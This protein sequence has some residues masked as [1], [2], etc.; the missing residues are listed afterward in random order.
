MA[1][2][3]VLQKNAR[4]MRRE[5]TASERKLWSLLRGGRV[6]G[7]KF[8]RQ[9]PLGAYIADFAC[10][11]PKVIVECDGGQHAGSAY[12]E[13]R[14]AWFEAQGFKVIR[15][16]NT[17]VI[18]NPEGVLE[19]IL[20][21]LGRGWCSSSHPLCGRAPPSPTRGEGSFKTTQPVPPPPRRPFRASD[22]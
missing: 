9:V 20:Q 8:R 1:D 6:A 2:R 11:Y 16:W 12:D 3:K 14:D 10:F 15:I 19:R 17:E 22:R 18:E 4:T 5:P 7:L 13:A 21:T